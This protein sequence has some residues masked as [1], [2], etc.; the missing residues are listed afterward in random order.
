MAWKRLP[1]VGEGWGKA[2]ARGAYEVGLEE[3]DGCGVGEELEQ[4]GGV[5]RI[6]KVCQGAVVAS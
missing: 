3:V 6:A 5:G 2:R 1:D 4:A